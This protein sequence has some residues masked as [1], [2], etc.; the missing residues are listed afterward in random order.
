MLRDGDG[1]EERVLY[2]YFFR[3]LIFYVREDNVISKM[4][5]K[6]FIVV[7]KLKGGQCDLPKSF[8]LSNCFPNDAFLCVKS[9]IFLVKRTELLLV[10][11]YLN[12]F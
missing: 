9:N 12:T 7:K 3:H 1:R 6:D 5:R 4:M 11:P 10:L 8:S 2:Y